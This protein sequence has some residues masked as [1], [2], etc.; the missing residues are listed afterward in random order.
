MLNPKLETLNSKQT[1]MPETQN[2]KQYNPL[3]LE[4][5]FARPVKYRMS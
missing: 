5:R 4:F 3:V 2:S 1:Q